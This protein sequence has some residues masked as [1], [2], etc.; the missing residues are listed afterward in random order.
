MIHLK[1]PDESHRQQSEDPIRRKGNSGVSDGSIRHRPR[2]Y[3]STMLALVFW[4]TEL[5]IAQ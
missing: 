2:R 1:V 4:M 3:T 5:A